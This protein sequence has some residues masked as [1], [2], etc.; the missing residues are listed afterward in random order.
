[1][2]TP[3]T[4]P[5]WRLPRWLD[6]PAWF[7]AGKLQRNPSTGKV[8]RKGSTGKALR[9]AAANT[10]CCCQSALCAFCA[11]GTTP[12]AYLLTL[13]PATECTTCVNMGGGYYGRI[14]AGVIAGTYCVPWVGGCGWTVD[15]VV[16]G[17]QATAYSD[18]SCST[19]VATTNMLKLEITR[20]ST[21]FVRVLAGVWFVPDFTGGFAAGVNFPFFE[22]QIT[23]TS[24]CTLTLSG[25]NSYTGTCGTFGGF[26]A[27]GGTC[28]A[29]PG[30]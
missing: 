9:N 30:C 6:L 3:R 20:G 13:A 14:T 24:D 11:A 16:P 29:T 10:K 26:L 8:K 23:T 25:N 21:T 4:A 19:V 28:T 18:S 12:S 1:L 5:W 17:F 15:Y 22:A 27:Y 7:T 2:W